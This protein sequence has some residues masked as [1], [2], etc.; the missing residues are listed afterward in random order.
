MS[1]EAIQT[2]QTVVAAVPVIDNPIDGVVPDFTV[3]GAE[4]NSWWKKLFGALWAIGIIWTLVQLV[5]AIAAISQAKG[6]HPSEL[7]ENRK[8]A[9]TSG[10]ALALLASLGVIVPAILAVVG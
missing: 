3:F 8:S 2:L 5:I 9:I 10:A 7:Q 1:I 4:F 6:S